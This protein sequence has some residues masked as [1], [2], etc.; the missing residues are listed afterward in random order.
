MELLGKLGKAASISTLD[1]EKGHHQVPVLEESFH[2]MAFLTPQAKWA[3]ICMY[4]C[5]YVCMQLGLKNASSTCQRLLNTITAVMAESP[6]QTWMTL[7]FTV[8]SSQIISNVRLEEKG[9]KLKAS[10]CVGS[11]AM[12]VLETLC[13]RRNISTTT[14]GVAD[15]DVIKDYWIMWPVNISAQ[16]TSCFQRPLKKYDHL[17]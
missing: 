11:E 15:N 2:K 17:K 9:V 10:K 13:G 7:S 14:G 4:V 8:A 3:Y 1:R 12:Q 5:M 16:N 6:L